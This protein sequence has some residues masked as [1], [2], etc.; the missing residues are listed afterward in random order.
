VNNEVIHFLFGDCLLPPPPQI[1]CCRRYILRLKMG[2]SGLSAAGNGSN[3]SMLEE[4]RKLIA[5][6]GDQDVD[7][8]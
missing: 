2:D 3:E 4:A 6:L 1:F 7:P 8:Q 5:S